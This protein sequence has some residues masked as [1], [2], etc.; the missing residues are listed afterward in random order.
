VSRHFSFAH[1]IR[2]KHRGRSPRTL[3]RVFKGNFVLSEIKFGLSRL[4]KRL[5]LYAYSA[6]RIRAASTSLQSF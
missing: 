3:G 2:N 4:D 1:K 5:W 6:R